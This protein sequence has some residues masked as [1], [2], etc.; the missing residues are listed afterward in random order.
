MIEA[1]KGKKILVTGGTGSIGFKIVQKLLAA[2][3]KVIRVFSRD[4]TKQFNARIRL[5]NDPRVTFLLG[6]IRDKQR[7]HMAMEGIDIVFHAAALKHVQ[8]IEHDPYEAVKTNVLGTQHVIEC[9]LARRVEKVVGISSDKAADPTSVLGCTK[10]LS[11]KLMQAA[12]HYKGSKQ[13]QFCFVRFGNVVGSRGSVIPLFCR[14]VKQGGPI[15]LTDPAMSRFFMSTGDAVDLVFKAANLTRDREIFILKMPVIRIQDLAEA[16]RDWYAPLCG[17]DSGS[18]SITT[19]GKQHGER[20]H[21]IL[22]GRDECV[23]AL[24]TP[25]MVIL[26][27]FVSP[28]DQETS[29]ADYPS[30]HHVSAKEFSTASPEF[31]SQRLSK[32]QIIALL[33][34]TR[35]DIESSIF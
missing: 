35:E 5:N 26:K 19:I 1:F 16:V 10:L 8:A 21:E 27:P 4:D 34:A 24:E 32:T 20:L 31:Q 3:P 22:V 6:D 17:R 12:F 15:T 28:W 30:A 7:L 11:E 29:D 9:A 23:N 25:D 13:T 33:N 2:D 14:Q 18:I